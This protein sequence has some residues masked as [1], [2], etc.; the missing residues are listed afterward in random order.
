MDPVDLVQAQVPDMLTFD[1]DREDLLVRPPFVVAEPPLFL[2]ERRG[3]SLALG[4]IRAHP[5]V[6]ECLPN[7]RPV[8]ELPS[9][10]EIVAAC[11]VK[12]RAEGDPAPDEECGEVR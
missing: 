9:R 8:S 1:L 10:D 11:I 7:A 2:R 3:A 6:P 12:A 5:V 4:R